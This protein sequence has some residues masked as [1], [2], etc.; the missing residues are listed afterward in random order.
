MPMQRIL[1]GGLLALLLLLPAAPA[2][3]E[4][5]PNER[6]QLSEL[7]LG[8]IVKVHGRPEPAPRNTRAAQVFHTVAAQASRTNV[9]YRLQVVESDQVNAYALPDGRIVFFTGLLDALPDQDLS[10]LAF[11]A[12]HEIAHVE[13]RHAERL[14]QRKLATMV[15]VRLLTRN[16]EDWVQL[17]GGFAYNLFASGY[18]REMEA[19]A[20][21]EAME[22]M[23]R[24]SYDPH[25][26]LKTLALFRDSSG[27]GLR[28]FPTH[29]DPADRY[30]DAVAWIKGNDPSSPLFLA[31]TL[32]RMRQEARQADSLA[33]SLWDTVR[34]QPL[35]PE[36]RDAEARRAL[37]TLAESTHN[38]VESLDG[39]PGLP[40]S[41]AQA[42]HGAFQEWASQRDELILGAAEKAR[43]ADLETRVSRLQDY[44]QVAL[45]QNSRLPQIA[46]DPRP[47]QTAAR[48]G[49]RSAEGSA[50]S[51]P[52][53]RAAQAPGTNRLPALQTLWPPARE[54]SSPARQSPAGH[55][56]PSALA[57][58]RSAEALWSQV[59]NLPQV[60]GDEPARLALL[61]LTERSRKLVH[62]LQ[63]GSGQVRPSVR[64]LQLLARDWLVRRRPLELS[65]E[66]SRLER[67][68]LVSLENLALASATD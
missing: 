20:D 23:R 2:Q 54:T 64:S 15:L 48:P 50:V 61:E 62:D 56:L 28:F 30:K 34:N 47:T 41:S 14:F 43:A 57:L 29:P 27:R 53:A 55:I 37:L 38:L 1:I 60:P 11:V 42:V 18:S 67:A 51:A 66:N 36:E 35:A 45:E 59:R 4:L 16:S 33:Q 32:D 52:M 24:S 21:R 9:Q 68:M 22:L 44:F 65:A 26:A 5:G 63:G 39:S 13:K 12:A 25:G 19:E 3:A 6:E 31:E 58:Q 46:V 17:M 10:P 49:S 8:Q 7:M 40:H